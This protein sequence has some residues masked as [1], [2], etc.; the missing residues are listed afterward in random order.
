MMKVFWPNNGKSWPERYRRT[1][2]NYMAAEQRRTGVVWM[3]PGVTAMGP[4]GPDP[5]SIQ[6]GPVLTYTYNMQVRAK[7]MA[8]LNAHIRNWPS[9]KMAGVPVVSALQFQGNSPNLEATYTLSLTII[10]RDKQPG[11]DPR[12]G[13]T[14]S[15]GG[16]G[17]GG[18]GGG[19]RGGGP[20]RQG[21]FG[22]GG[23]APGGSG[24]MMSGGGGGGAPGSP[25]RAGV[26]AGG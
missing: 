25:S 15:G 23:G 21:G 26:S 12:V 20:G 16:G 11:P 4:F 3:N 2:F 5:N 17:F 13:G 22:G 24:G 14:S 9:I 19:P 18:G 7:S 1:L 10:V 6:L 8:A